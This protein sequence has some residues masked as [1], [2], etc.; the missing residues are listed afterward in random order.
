MFYLYM[1]RQKHPSYVLIKRRVVRRRTFK[2]I[3]WT[4]ERKKRTFE[5]QKSGHLSGG[6]LG[7]LNGFLEIGVDI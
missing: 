6:L 4:K 2:R 5:R 3:G 1:S 7:H